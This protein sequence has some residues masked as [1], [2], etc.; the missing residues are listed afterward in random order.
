MVK[1]HISSIIRFGWVS[2]R[3]DIS[4]LSLIFE[5]FRLNSKFQFIF[6]LFDFVLLFNISIFVL[7]SIIFGHFDFIWKLNYIEFND[8]LHFREE[9][10]ANEE[11]FEKERFLV[12]TL[13]LY[14]QKLDPLYGTEDNETD[15]SKNDATSN[16]VPENC[17][18]YRKTDEN[19]VLFAGVNKKAGGSNG[20][21]GGKKQ[22]VRSLNI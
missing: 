3:S 15:N 20:K 12:S 4:I 6:A 10:K 9:I 19:D 1:S 16:A 22:K 18:A 7:R 14:C 2:D 17:I 21:K 5:F 13:I 11:P 8:N